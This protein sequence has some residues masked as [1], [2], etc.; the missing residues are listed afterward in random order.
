MSVKSYRAIII[1]D[2]KFM[3]DVLCE[4]LLAHKEIEIAGEAESMS[5][6]VLLLEDFRPDVVFLDIQLKEETG[7]DLVPHIDPGTHIVFFTG[8]D[9][10]AIRAFEVNALDYLLKPVEAERLAAT[11]K[12][13]KDRF[14]DREASPEL[15]APFKESDKV[16]VRTDN[17][18]R[19]IDIKNISAVASLGGNYTVLHLIDGSKYV[20]RRTM[21][22]WETQLPTDIFQRI[23]R[24]NIVNLH[25]INSLIMDDDGVWQVFLKTRPEPFE[26]SK[27][28]LQDLKNRLKDA[29]GQPE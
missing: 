2:D 18:Q 6:A 5:E 19:F 8:Y 22:N 23:H 3:R 26:V 20:V 4:M 10:Y 15:A 17:E 12:R 11:I 16:F 21:K 29:A 1:D 25:Q 14:Q 13:L 7:F 28:R 27:R 9:Q 24:S